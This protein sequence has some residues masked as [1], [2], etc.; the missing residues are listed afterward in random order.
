MRVY[1]L[2]ICFSYNLWVAKLK[3]DSEVE[4]HHICL[5]FCPTLGVLKLSVLDVVDIFLVAVFWEFC[6]LRLLGSCWFS[7]L[8]ARARRLVGLRHRYGRI[9]LLCS[10][11][12]FVQVCLEVVAKTLEM[13]VGGL[14]RE[15]LSFTFVGGFLLQSVSGSP[16]T[17]LYFWRGDSRLAGLWRRCRFLS[18]PVDQVREFSRPW[19]RQD[20]TGCR[21]GLGCRRGALGFEPCGGG[22]GHL[23]PELGCGDEP[24]RQPAIG[25]RFVSG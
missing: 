11:A 16:W 17:S 25:Q 9:R 10:A 2:I 21:P 18:L 7:A 12:A 4:F 24:A 8:R 23:Q 6:L 15:P 19:L 5:L 3:W 13:R 22:D 1:L 20:G 14:F